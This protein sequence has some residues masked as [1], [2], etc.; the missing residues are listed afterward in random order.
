MI[1]IP[2]TS[3]ISRLETW[4][5]SASKECESPLSPVRV[6]N[7]QKSKISSRTFLSSSR[8]ICFEIQ[9]LPSYITHKNHNVCIYHSRMLSYT[10]MH[11]NLHR[12]N[13]ILSRFISPA[14]KSYFPNGRSKINTQ[15]KTV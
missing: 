11:H 4:S 3:A 10:R 2:P 8:W 12:T 13:H 6:F 14:G 7:K 5:D 1:I 9:H 15:N